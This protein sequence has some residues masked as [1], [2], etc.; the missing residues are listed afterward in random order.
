[1]PVQIGFPGEIGHN[2]TVRAL[3]D[4]DFVRGGIRRV[5]NLT[6]LYELVDVSD[7]TFGQV[8]EY[9]TLVWVDTEDSFYQLTDVANINVA[10]GW[11]KFSTST[12]TELNFTIEDGNLLLND[13]IV[14]PVTGDQGPEGTGIESITQTQDGS[15]NIQLTDGSDP[16][17]ITLV[18]GS[19]GAS[20]Y[21]IWLSLQPDPTGLTEQ[22]FID[23]LVG[24]NGV[25]GDSAYDIWLSQENSGSEADFLASLEG[26]DG[27]DGVDGNTI[28]SGPGEPTINDG[29]NGD[30]WYD[31]QNKRL[32]GPKSGGTWSTSYVD[33]VAQDGVTPTISTD[34]TTTTLGEGENATASINDEGD[35][36]YSLSLGIPAGA[37]GQNGS[38]GNT[39]LSGGVDPTTEGVDGDFYINTASST[40][41]GPKSGG[42]WGD[43][44]SLLGDA[45]PPIISEELTPQVEDGYNDFR[46]RVNNL[47]F[48]A[49]TPI[50]DIV[51]DIFRPYVAAS[52]HL[53][54]VNISLS[55]VDGSFTN[56]FSTLGTFDIGRSIKVNYVQYDVTRR[57]QLTGVVNV[58]INNSVQETVGLPDSDDNNQITS[59]YEAGPFVNVTTLTFKI[60][61]EDSVTGSISSN[62]RSV[63]FGYRWVIGFDTQ[64]NLEISNEEA[65]SV[66]SS[67]VSSNGSDYLTASNSSSP[68]LFNFSG[69]EYSDPAN[70]T[71]IIYPKVW[72]PINNIY[73]GTSAAGT[74]VLVDFTRIVNSGAG[75]GDDQYEFTITNDYGVDIDY[76]IYRTVGP[77]AF[78]SSQSI[79]IV[80]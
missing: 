47:T 10:D 8:S 69:E 76:Y 33:L 26:S 46:N 52:I 37:T 44:T 45:V 79:Y 15:F 57:D 34:V 68:R 60:Q 53:D 31:T 50:E 20:A 54:L 64:S 35:N 67:I 75:D 1:M 43:G 49:N 74:P 51:F 3:V 16:I 13:Q 71:Y 41:F 42:I 78:E 39:I 59:D 27:E 62:S 2:N 30:F 48:S 11:T 40:I 6:E 66:F 12:D 56:G 5:A 63:Y 73:L 21:D 24:Q 14:G 72:T 28:L 77:G 58:I 7:I 25:N 4:S 55:N 29:V 70:Y 36:V 22:D 65:S 32:Y 9:R 23:S 61:A 38:D 17:T 19:D 18:N 80:F